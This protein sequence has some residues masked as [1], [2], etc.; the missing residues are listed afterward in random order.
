[1][2]H[3]A[4]IPIQH[5]RPVISQVKWSSNDWLLGGADSS[6]IYDQMLQSEQFYIML[7]GHNVMS[8]LHWCG[9]W[10]LGDKQVLHMYNN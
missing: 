10:D 4:K 7:T 8:L 9:G 1:M 3:F 6:Q 5:G 2:T